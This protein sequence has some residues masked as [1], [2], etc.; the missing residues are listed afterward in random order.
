MTQPNITWDLIKGQWLL[1]RSSNA[2]L[3]F[4][5]AN[6]KA[7]FEDGKENNIDTNLNITSVFDNNDDVNII[8][9]IIK[10]I[11]TNKNITCTTDKVK[12]I[13]KTQIQDVI[14]KKKQVLTQPQ[15]NNQQQV[16][17]TLTN[18]SRNQTNK[19]KKT[20]DL[21]AKQVF[22]KINDML[23]EGNKI[24]RD[25]NASG[26]TPEKTTL[27]EKLFTKYEKLDNTHLNKKK[28]ILKLL[29]ISVGFDDKTTFNNHINN[30]RD[31]EAGDCKNEQFKNLKLTGTQEEI[32]EQLKDAGF[33]AVYKKEDSSTEDDNSIYSAEDEDGVEH[34][35]LTNLREETLAKAASLA[36]SDTGILTDCTGATP[37]QQKTIEKAFLSDG[38]CIS[39]S[40]KESF[41]SLA[42]QHAAQGIDKLDIAAGLDYLMKPENNVTDDDKRMFLEAVIGKNKERLMA[43][44]KHTNYDQLKDLLNSDQ[45]GII[46][47]EKRAS[48]PNQQII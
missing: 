8:E 22:E 25:V 38:K 2:N 11:K 5:D 18:N 36:P 3:A 7:I 10:N 32:I 13:I 48:S 4:K 34:T 43:L 23:E 29:K 44:I 12:E 6:L 26:T 9:T 28:E 21:T 45:K 42:L 41:A 30:L 33:H 27:M 17:L 47:T 39:F 37:E 1:L 24:E 15:K 46:E 14:D 40:G 19:S 16:N 35:V 20:K 31:V